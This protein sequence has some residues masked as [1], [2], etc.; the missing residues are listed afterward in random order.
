VLES[1]I[2]RCLQTVL[3]KALRPPDSERL[4]RCD[5]N[6]WA[7]GSAPVRTPWHGAGDKNMPTLQYLVCWDWMSARHCP[8][9]HAHPSVQDWLLPPLSKRERCRWNLSVSGSE[10]EGR[11]G[12]R[13]SQEAG[14]LGVALGC[15]LC[16]RRALLCLVETLKTPDSCHL[17]L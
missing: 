6:I 1:K 8:H 10:W 13:M 5:P 2:L 16:I 17:A 7:L 9:Y 3:I 15:C 11:V 12:L 4:I 14:P